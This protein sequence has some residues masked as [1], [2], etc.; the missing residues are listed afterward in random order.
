MEIDAKL[1][2][3]LRD[4]SGLPMM[5]CKKA[6]QETNGDLDKAA[7]WLAKQG[8]KIAEKKAGRETK[9]GA[10]GTYLHHD[11]RTAVLV[12]VNCESAQVAKTEDFL[13]LCRDL[14]LHIAFHDPVAVSRE[15]VPAEIVAKE[16]EIILSVMDQDP[17]M[18][19]KPAEMKSKIAEGKLGRFFAERVLLEQPF[20]K[21]TSGK[22]S[23]KDRIDQAVLKVRENITVRRYVRFRVGDA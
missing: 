20:V 6:L 19:D 7:D 15:A 3:Q 23:V 12:E 14:A 2:K 1:V 21:D 10:I 17:K 16:R 18:A 13:A 22:T 5:Q 11:G 4:R 9:E 8:A